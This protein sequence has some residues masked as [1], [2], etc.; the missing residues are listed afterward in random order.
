MMVVDM[1]WRTQKPIGWHLVLLLGTWKPLA[2]EGLDHGCDQQIGPTKGVPDIMS[3]R[4]KR[5]SNQ[6]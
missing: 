4:M 1:L 6:V 2:S 3:D 5:I